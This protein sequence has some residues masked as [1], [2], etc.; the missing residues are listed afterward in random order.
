MAERI[1]AGTSSQEQ[2]LVEDSD[3][4]QKDQGYPAR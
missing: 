1:S 4:S 2:V 3:V